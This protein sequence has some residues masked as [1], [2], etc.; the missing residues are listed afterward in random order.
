M[1]NLTL[2]LVLLVAYNLYHCRYK[3]STE[4]IVDRCVISIFLLVLTNSIPN[5]SN[6]TYWLI[7]GLVYVC[8]ITLSYKTIKDNL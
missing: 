4:E 8:F 3:L 6:T 7:K 1:I 2:L 5:S